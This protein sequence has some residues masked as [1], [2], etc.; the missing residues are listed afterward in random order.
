MQLRRTQF[1]RWVDR[2]LPPARAHALS[3][4]NLFIFPSAR[5]LAYLAVMLVVWVIG[6][7]YQNNLVLALAFFMVSFFVVGILHTF[8]NLSGLRVEYVGAGDA[9][10][11]QEFS[12][13]FK[14]VVRRQRAVH[15]VSVCWSGDEKAGV[16]LSCDGQGQLEFSVP[17]YTDQRGKLALPRMSVSSV[18]PLGIIRCWTWLNWDVPVLVFPAPMAYPLHAATTSDDLGD[19]LHPVRGGEDFS[20]L[21]PYQPGDSL[22]RVA[23]KA[24]AR[25]QGV[26]VK[27]FQQNASRE[28]WLDFDALQE[29]DR[30]RRL[31][32]LC[33]WVLQYFQAEEHFGLILPTQK[34]QPDKGYQHRT[35]CLIALA[36][37]PK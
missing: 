8:L 27:D 22:R 23:W 12:L 4:K 6:T 16:E 30:E 5:G 21:K 1:M 33:Y 26:F 18:F 32:V 25:G 36:E 13:R 11:G 3:Q 9:F 2:R 7:N 17:L 31:S 14:L 34:V 19:G 20:G 15:A 24:F 28:H 10:A 29:L 37:F 35:R